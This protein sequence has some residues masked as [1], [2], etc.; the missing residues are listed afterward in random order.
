[1]AATQY[2]LAMQT[3]SRRPAEGPAEE[4][5]PE[6]KSDLSEFKRGLVVGARWAGLN[7]SE[8]NDL[9]GFLPHTFINRLVESMS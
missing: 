3:W 1:M 9:L 7:I 2:R 5:S 8:T 4:W 6:T